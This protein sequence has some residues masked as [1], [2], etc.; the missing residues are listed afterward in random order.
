MKIEIRVIYLILL[1]AFFSRIFYIHMTNFPPLEG[2]AFFYDKEAKQILDNFVIGYNSTSPNSFV[3]PGFPIFLAI[4]YKVFG[5]HLTFVRD[6]Q[7][8]LSVITIYICYCISGRYLKSPYTELVAAL[9]TFYPSF[10][11]ANGLILTEVL[12]TFLFLL[13]VFIFI[14]AMENI[15]KILF[16]FGWNY[17]CFFNFSSS[18]FSTAV[19]CIFYF[20]YNY[21]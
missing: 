19:Y 18:Y 20:L 5:V 10:I 6:I 21:C 11:Y 14:K 9:M 4:I 7:V 1:L 17:I 12:F 16:Y 15:E 8:I 2:D 3:T 13:F